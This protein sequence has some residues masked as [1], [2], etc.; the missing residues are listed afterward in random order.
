LEDKYRLYLTQNK[1]L[2]HFSVSE[3]I[4]SSCYYEGYMA[5]L[6]YG[7]RIIFEKSIMA[8]M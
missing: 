3:F 1:Y 2:V 4:M 7:L 6:R 5:Y 8:V